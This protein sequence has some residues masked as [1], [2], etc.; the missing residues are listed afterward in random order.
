MSAAVT[1]LAP[2]CGVEDEA[3]RRA[4]EAELRREICDAHVLA[5]VPVTLLAR[6][7]DMDEALYLLPDGR[8]AEVHLTW[9]RQRETDPRWPT[10]AIY[11]SLETWIEQ[12]MRPKH[13]WFG[14]W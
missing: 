5:G 8:L 3:E 6:R 12:S 7:G 10:T 2:W 4:L 1:W 11:A 9:S 13:A 14:E